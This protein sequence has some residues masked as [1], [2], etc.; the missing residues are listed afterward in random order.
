MWR[1]FLLILF[2]VMGCADESKADAGS[3]GAGDGA[4]S[5]DHAEILERLDALEA[6]LAGKTAELEAYGRG[7]GWLTNFLDAAKKGCD[8][9]SGAEKDAASAAKALDEEE[10]AGKDDEDGFVTIS[11]YLPT[12]GVTPDETLFALTLSTS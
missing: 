2:M 11:R 9:D 4:S 12:M 3:D 10:E 7:R 1:A 5:H 6:D 8:T